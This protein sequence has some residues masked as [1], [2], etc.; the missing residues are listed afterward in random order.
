MNRVDMFN[1]EIWELNLPHTNIMFKG[2]FIVNSF[3]MTADINTAII[4]NI[5]L[6]STGEIETIRG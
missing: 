1:K 6:I 5:N 3:I 4:G 2:E